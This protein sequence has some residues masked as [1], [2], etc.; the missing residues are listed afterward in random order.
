MTASNK[1]VGAEGKREEGEEGDSDSDSEDEEREKWGLG[2]RKRVKRKKLVKSIRC[3]D[4][5]VMSVETSREHFCSPRDDVGP[6]NGVEVTY[7][8]EWEDLL[9][10][11]KDNNTDHTPYICGV[12]PTLYVNVSPHVVRAVIHKHG[13]QSLDSGR[14]PSME[15]FDEDG[16][17]W[18]AAAEPPSSEGTETETEEDGSPSPPPPS[19]QQHGTPTPVATT[20]TAGGRT[21]EITPPHTLTDS[22]LSPIER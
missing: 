1:E 16:Y 4:G 22:E 11:Y 15:E 21:G 3:K 20:T 19:Q 7:P 18:A 6:Y 13:G 12:A 8:S 9:L 2:K 5:F 17:M 10:P 14:L